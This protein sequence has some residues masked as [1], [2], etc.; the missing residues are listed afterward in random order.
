MFGQKSLFLKILFFEISDISGLDQ[1][2]VCMWHHAGNFCFEIKNL[3]FFLPSIQ[4]NVSLDVNSNHFNLLPCV[5]KAQARA[6]Y[7]KYCFGK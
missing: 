1:S 5:K 7:R 4:M 3:N 6:M 2:A